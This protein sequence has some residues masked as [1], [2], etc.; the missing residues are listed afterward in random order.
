MSLQFRLQQEVVNTEKS[1]NEAVYDRWQELKSI[2]RQV[3]S[4]LED[5]RKDIDEK[6]SNGEMVG[7]PDAMLTLQ[8]RESLSCD[9][10]DLVKDLGE[11]IA[12]RCAD[13]SA[14]KL[15]KMIE[16]GVVPADAPYIKRT[17]T[18]VLTTKVD[19]K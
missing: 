5:L 14:S 4:A 13:V 18:T 6:M 9:M 2:E 10:D 7:Y 11:K 15:R 19:R 3:K 8:E 1:D 16:A 12:L 17:V